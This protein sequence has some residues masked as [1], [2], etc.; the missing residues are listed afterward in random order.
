MKT[1]LSEIFH[2]HNYWKQWKENNIEF[3]TNRDKNPVSYFLVEYIDCTQFENEEKEVRNALNNLEKRF[4]SFDNK[5]KAIKKSIARSFKDVEDIAQL[6]KNTSAIYAVKLSNMNVLDNYRNII[7]SIEE[8]PKYFKR[9]VLPYNDLQL[10]ELKQALTT[11]VKDATF[12]ELLTEIANDIEKKEH[13]EF[14]EANNDDNNNYKNYYKLLKGADHDNAYE[15]AIRLF[16]KIPFLQYQFKPTTSAYSLEKMIKGDLDEELKKFDGKVADQIESIDEYLKLDQ[17][18][19]PD[20]IIN[21]ELNK[22]LEM[23]GNEQ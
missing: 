17:S 16:S 12:E 3:Y 14:D 2:E 18:V 8:S 7:Y 4:L 10:N 19:I 11:D 21:E 23:G 6:D 20:E 22:L 1:L 5:E 15:L 9:Y 13:K